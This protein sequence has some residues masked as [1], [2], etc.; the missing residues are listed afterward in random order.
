MILVVDAP[1]AVASAK[2]FDHAKAR[3]ESCVGDLRSTKVRLSKVVENL[4]G[5]FATSAREVSNASTRPPKPSDFV[6]SMHDSLDELRAELNEL[7]D[8]VS[9]LESSMQ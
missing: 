9:A 8:A 6:N 4:I 3:V 7:A 2:S 5:P 1:R